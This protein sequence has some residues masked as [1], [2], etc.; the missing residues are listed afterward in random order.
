MDN[1]RKQSFLKYVPGL[2]NNAVLKLIIA[3]GTA[4]VILGIILGINLIVYQNDRSNFFHYFIGN[5]ALP[6]L[7]DFKTHWWTIF[8]Y[9][10]FHFSG[11][12][13][14]LRNML[15]LYCF[16]SVVQMLIGHRQVIP[17][18]TYALIAGGI[19]YLL[20]QFLPGK[21]GDIN[22]H[23]PGILG[24]RA[25][26]IAMAVAAV[27]ISPGFYFYLTETFRIHILVV[28]GI[29]TL[30]MILSTGFIVP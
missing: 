27:T 10:W 14:C 6:Q 1:Q 26:L 15:W 23:L 25:G 19:F 20:A 24:A 4:F 12:W 5:L 13:E 3:S 30:L 9:G 11:F 16:G 7:A 29:F 2:T 8:T 28:A 17:L 22:H 18:Y 21:P